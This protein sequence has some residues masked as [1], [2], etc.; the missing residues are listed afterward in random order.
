MN[1]TMLLFIER[2]KTQCEGLDTCIQSQT[3][4]A[5]LLRPRILVFNHECHPRPWCIDKMRHNIL[6]KTRWT[7]NYLD[8]LL[9]FQR[10]VSALGTLS[11]N[12]W[13]FKLIKCSM[14]RCFTQGEKFTMLSCYDSTAI[15]MLV[16]VTLLQF[17]WFS[18]RLFFQIPVCKLDGVL[19]IVSLL[20]IAI[21]KTKTFRKQNFTNWMSCTQNH[22]KLRQIENV[23]PANIHI[24]CRSNKYHEWNT[25]LIANTIPSL[26]L[27][28]NH[29]LVCM[30]NDATW[31]RTQIYEPCSAPSQ[32][33]L[34]CRLVR[35][36][37]L[38]DTVKSYLFPNSKHINVF[39]KVFITL[40]FIWYTFLK[41]SPFDIQASNLTC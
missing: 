15:N 38:C 26:L 27:C 4:P 33:H 36:W 11:L 39:I 17:V 1:K 40:K 20:V 16:C 19:S 21:M 30:P 34:V 14:Y 6:W 41:Y 2:R 31:R 22:R 24:C 9:T 29:A 13:M 18:L 7:S 32:L 28:L 23:W 12:K 3:D 25:L 10:F 35:F 5:T 8:V 37:C